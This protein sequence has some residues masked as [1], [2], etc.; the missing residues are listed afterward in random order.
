MGKNITALIAGL[1][2]GLGLTISQMINPAKV[3]GFL[4]V[5]GGW[6]PSLAFV[7]GGAVL[8]TSTGFRLVWKKRR[9]IFEPAFEIPSNR[10]IDTR[11]GAG[12]VLFGL[13]WG[14]VGLC[15]GPAIAGLA[16][17]GLPVIVFV[18][19]M[20]AGMVGVALFDRWI[21][22]DAITQPGDG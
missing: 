11:L 1:I 18:I 12:A 5:F 15:P 21:K 3:I 7:M 4:D 13:G 6:D 19:A 8:V 20:A 17:G 22:Q 10:K 9:P 14:V 2:F 16:V